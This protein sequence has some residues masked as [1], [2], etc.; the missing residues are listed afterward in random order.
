MCPPF[1]VVRRIKWCL[2]TVSGLPD[3]LGRLGTDNVRTG[4]VWILEAVCVVLV[5]NSCVPGWAFYPETLLS[6]FTKWWA[7]I[8]NTRAQRLVW[9]GTNQWEQGRAFPGRC[10][11]QQRSL[12][13]VCKLALGLTMRLVLAWGRG[14]C[15]HMTMSGD[16][17]TGQRWRFPDYS[18]DM[19]TLETRRKK[20]QTPMHAVL[21][22]QY[23]FSN[24]L[25]NLLTG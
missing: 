10:R 9:V 1:K 12:T 18:Q 3:S 24:H 6:V 2:R 17:H 22:H 21:W 15:R 14:L 25:K 4:R 16:R 13:M 5:T 19:C 8:A 11:D 23:M 20:Q 7:T